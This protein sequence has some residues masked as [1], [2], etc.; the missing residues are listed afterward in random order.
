MDP[1]LRA[2]LIACIDAG[3]AARAAGDDH[4]SNPHLAAVNP[5]ALAHEQSDAI[6]RCEAW[7]DGFEEADRSL[8]GPAEPRRFAA[9]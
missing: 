9:Y 4:G 6:L 1:R 2:E 8:S 3:A 7:W 5:R